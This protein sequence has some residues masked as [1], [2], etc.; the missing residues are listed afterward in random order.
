MVEG[1]CNEEGVVFEVGSF[2]TWTLRLESG[3]GSFTYYLELSMYLRDELGHQQTD[4][5][6]L[7]R[8]V[9]DPTH[10]H[11]SAGCNH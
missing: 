2:A 8:H 7:L 1:G 5:F 3:G 11:R 6:H 9:S 4:P 10:H